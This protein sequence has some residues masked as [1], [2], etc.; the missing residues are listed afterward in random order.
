MPR[1]ADRPRR[2]STRGKGP[3]EGKAIPR[4]PQRASHLGHLRGTPCFCSRVQTGAARDTGAAAA[5]CVTGRPRARARAAARVAS[6]GAGAGG[7]AV[8]G[9]VLGRR[10]VDRRGG[11]LTGGERE[12]GRALRCAVIWASLML[13]PG[14][15]SRGVQLGGAGAASQ[16]GPGE[17]MQGRVPWAGQRGGGRGQRFG[18]IRR[19]GVHSRGYVGVAGKGVR[20]TPRGSLVARR[21]GQPARG[22][23]QVQLAR[24]TA[25][26]GARTGA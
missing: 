2:G 12:Q 10:G 1:K 11:A 15:S 25:A 9:G 6:R 21:V 20:G 4:R 18:C 19:C 5:T 7:S 8:M 13:V 24:R 23:T 26:W 17:L 14:G 16:V 3:R 22:V